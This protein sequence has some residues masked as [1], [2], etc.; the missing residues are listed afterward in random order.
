V[1]P[2]DVTARN[3]WKDFERR[4]AKR[5]GGRRIPVTGLDR[6]GADVETPLLCV[7]VKL[8]R[9]MPSYFRE[10]MGGIVNTAERK[11]KIG[12]VVWKPFQSRDDN[13]IVMMRLKDFE[14][15]HGKIE[16]AA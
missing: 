9:R 8:G 6:H 7:Q 15:L 1:G 13:A 3:T 11:K 16:E 2:E 10:W 12:A 14:E 5:L 4:T